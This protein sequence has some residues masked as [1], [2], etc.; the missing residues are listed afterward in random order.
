MYK[1]AK[2][3]A[4]V[5]LPCPEAGAATKMAGQQTAD[6]GVLSQSPYRS[7]SRVLEIH[8]QRHSKRPAGLW[9]N[10]RRGAS[11]TAESLRVI[12]AIG[13]V[14]DPQRKFC[15]LELVRITYI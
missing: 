15:I 2:A 12:L 10:R 11:S 6:K 5:V 9:I 8:A 14:A 4:T 1:R 13:Q 7:F 3:Q